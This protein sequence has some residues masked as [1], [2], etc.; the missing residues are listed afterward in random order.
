MKKIVIICGTN[1]LNRDTP[2]DISNPL[3]W[4]PILILLKQKQ[5]KIIVSGIL[6]R[7]KGNNFRRQKLLQ[8]N[9][10]LKEKC[11]RIPKIAYLEPESDWVRTV[12]NS[13]SKKLKVIQIVI[14]YR[15]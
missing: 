1:N 3:T 12:R 13:I 10:M 14:I 8:T 15:V 9:N 4:A 2:S 5:I 11:S 7:N 6:P